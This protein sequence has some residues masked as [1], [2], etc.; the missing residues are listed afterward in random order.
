[1]YM[2]VEAWVKRYVWLLSTAIW[3]LHLNRDYLGPAPTIYLSTVLFAT[4]LWLVIIFTL[5]FILKRLLSY[6][7]FMY[8][9]RGKVSL[10]TKLWG[11]STP[12]QKLGPHFFLT[13]KYMQFNLLH[14]MCHTEVSITYLVC[15][16]PSKMSFYCY[17]ISFLVF[18]WS[19][20]T[21][22]HV[23]HWKCSK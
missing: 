1:M 4:M 7:G 10:Q 3:T 11:V 8:E 18:P 22:V 15:R 23:C 21:R 16:K 13:H 17:E 19:P 2:E 6:K 9:G 14:F 12:S 20:C 5:R